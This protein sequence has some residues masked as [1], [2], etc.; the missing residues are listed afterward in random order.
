MN[1]E[2]I[3]DFVDVW[4][5]T[6]GL[7][8]TR[9]INVIKNDILKRCAMYEKEI[10]TIS[11]KDDSCDSYII[12]PV[13]ESYS[14]ED[15]FLNRLML[16]LR[17]IDFSSALE[18][19]SGEYTA[20]NKSLSVNVGMLN[21][22][23]SEKATRHKGLENKNIQIIKK[24][25][26]HELGHCFKSAFTNGYKAPLY[27][28]RTQDSI[29]EN[30][31]NNLTNYK[32][33]KYANQIKTV[34]E[35]NSNEYSEE[36]KVGVHDSKA[37]YNHDFRV[38]WID[39]MLNEAEALELTSSNDIH[40]TWPLQN[41]QGKNSPSGNYVNVYNYIS[42]YSTFTG[43][44]NI[45]KA[46]LGKE[47]CFN[48]E[49]ISSIDIFKEFDKEYADI[50]KEVWGLDNCL[51]IQAMYLDFN[52]LLNKKQFNENIMLKLDEFFVKCYQK[53]IDKIITQNNGNIDKSFVE[54]VL[55]D[56]E[57]FQSR[58][59]TNDDPQKRAL[60]AH[61]VIFNDITS[62]IKELSKSND[63]IITSYETKNNQEDTSIEIKQDDSQPNITEENKE[64]LDVKLQQGKHENKMKWIKKFIEMY[65]KTESELQYQTRFD[66]EDGNMQRVL[67]GI[68]LGIFRG[69]MSADLDG[70][71]YRDVG[72]EE[73]TKQ[74]SIKQLA[75][76]ARLLKAAD[77]LTV[78][79][80]KNY[81]EEFTNIPDINY[82]LL[83]M[84]K[85]DATKKMFEIAE[86][87]EKNGTIPKYKKTR[88]QIDKEYAE[89]YLKSGNLKL[90]S[91]EKEIEGRTE[92]AKND[93]I[94]ISQ[95]KDINDVS[96][97]RKQQVSL[98]RVLARQ[99]GKVPSKPLYNE[100]KKYWYC[101]MDENS[102]QLPDNPDEGPKKEKKITRS[103]IQKDTQDIGM[104]E[105]NNLMQE[106]KK[107]ELNR[108]MKHGRRR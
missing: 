65:E 58:L 106:I 21:S 83:E 60:L 15:F 75:A 90:G 66:M 3:S 1:K 10:S 59:T 32:N 84:K 38:Q 95:E 91:V 7:K 103:K 81:L 64:I 93:A 26:E 30:L 86:Q 78:E 43:Y 5:E 23:I 14:L 92:L 39:E 12:K 22:R 54:S 33:G 108:Q 107:N 6:V 35:L 87:N 99:Q 57:N 71:L 104:N 19:N 44:G 89:A 48:A 17:K 37:N 68:E 9:Y 24:T 98:T 80:G 100:N 18:G 74:Y 52:A 70:K 20:G 94:I 25:I 47:K 53:K 11:T 45:F 46:I 76:M 41:D 73:F 88:A 101:L 82:I 36:I 85:S 4:A 2:K 97:I 105:I 16:G 69:N 49:Y 42:G 67:E 102:I 51:P 40:E 62:R 28:D 63:E 61:N 8:E 72:E 13:N 96:L 27:S 29:Y 77:N 50:V 79:G 55:K 31:I 34:K 56:I